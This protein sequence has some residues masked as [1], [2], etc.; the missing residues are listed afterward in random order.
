MTILMAAGC[1]LYGALS[2]ILLFVLALVKG[3]HSTCALV[4]LS[5]GIAYVAQ[6]GGSWAYERNDCG[7][8][9]GWTGYVSVFATLV[10]VLV[11]VG[12]FLRLTF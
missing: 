4:I 6:F 5:A 2:L 11:G 9:P 12:A 7:V 1:F 3:D 8:A 10:S